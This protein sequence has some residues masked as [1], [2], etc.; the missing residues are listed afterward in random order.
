MLKRY[1]HDQEIRYSGCRSVRSENAFPVLYIAVFLYENQT[2]IM[3]GRKKRIRPLKCDRTVIG[4][5][6]PHSWQSLQ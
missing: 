1:V 2:G 5:R 3:R 6:R 4:F